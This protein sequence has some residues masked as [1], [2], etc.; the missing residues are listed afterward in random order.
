MN[1]DTL[2]QCG[3]PMRS[4]FLTHDACE[5]CVVDANHKAWGPTRPPSYAKYQDPKETEKRTTKRAR[6]QINAA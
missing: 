6:R 5:D 2:C 3:K 4:Y 1:G